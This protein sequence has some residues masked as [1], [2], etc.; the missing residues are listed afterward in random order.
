[1][2]TTLN[3]I[4]A[5]TAAPLARAGFAVAAVAA[6]AT[7]A[8]AAV[9]RAAGVSFD[10]KGEPIPLLAFPQLTFGFSLVGLAIASVLTRRA[11]RARTTFLRTTGVLLVL[12]FVPDL[13]SDASASTKVALVLVHVVAAAL[14]VPVLARR[15]ADRP[16]SA[17]A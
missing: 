17:V 2:T 12:S 9:V 7:L 3:E 6:I 14:V 15:L 4:N 16:T 5:P 1:M 11:T 10:I 13:T 8:V